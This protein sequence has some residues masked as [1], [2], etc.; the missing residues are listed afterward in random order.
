MVEAILVGTLAVTF[1]YEVVQF[2]D[3]H[4]RSMQIADRRSGEWMS[5]HLPSDAVVGSWDAGVLGY[6]A[7][8]PVVNLDGVVNS[9]AWLDAQR[10]GTTADYLDHRHV[11]YFANH[12]AVVD[13]QDPGIRH[14][15]TGLLGADA[16]ARLRQL[17]RFEFV[18]S[19]NI[20]GAS[21]TGNRNWASFVYEVPQPSG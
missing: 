14:D 6:F 13:G 11:R 8:R 19:G 12:A 5:A 17:K 2:D 16:A 7:D 4:Q 3:P 9:F 15:V 20:E 21:T 1:V 10:D 18:Y